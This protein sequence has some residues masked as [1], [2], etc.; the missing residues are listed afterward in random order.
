MSQSTSSDIRDLPDHSFQPVSFTFP[1]RSF[2]KATVVQRNFQLSWFHHWKRIHYDATMD[3]T[4][5]F[6]CCKAA[7]QGKIKSTGFAEGSFTNKGFTNWKD[8]IRIFAKHESSYAHKQ[9]TMC[10]SSNTDIAELLSTQHVR[11]KEQNHNYFLKFYQAFVTLLDKVY[12]YGEME[13]T[14]TPTFIN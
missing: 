14:K 2:G 1:L 4:F 3:T 13:V 6:S 12:F 11:E 10:I 5:C 7:K 9:S 8:A